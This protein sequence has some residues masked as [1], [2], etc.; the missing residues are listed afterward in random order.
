NLSARFCVDRR[1]VENHLAR[2]SRLQLACRSGLAEDGFDAAVPGVRSVI[3]ARFGL[4]SLGDLGIRGIRQLLVRAFPGSAGLLPLLVHGFFKA[5]PV[6][7]YSG[8]ARGIF[9]E[10]T[11]QS[12][13]VIQKEDLLAGYHWP[14]AFR[15]R[16][17]FRPWGREFSDAFFEFLQP[18]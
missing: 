4:E 3:E 9:D 2:V 15:R 7:R 8:V 16:R 14:G 1:T 5:G 13:G 11:G 17:G 10:V 18:S 12:V 6:D